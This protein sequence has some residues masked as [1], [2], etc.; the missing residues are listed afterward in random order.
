M[1]PFCRDVDLHLGATDDTV[2]PM[3]GMLPYLALRGGHTGPLFMLRDGRGLTHQLFSKALSNLLE[4]LHMGSRS[5][6]TH[7]FRI[8]VAT[9][10]KTANIPDTYIEI[11]GQ[12]KSDSY[13]CY[14]K[15]PPDKLAKLSKYLTT[16]YQL[17]PGHTSKK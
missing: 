3:R 12:W 6:N 17:S 10:A 8:G 9:S 16:G 7:S 2:C 5:Y 11:M 4:E 13:Q 14:I 15:T 1:D